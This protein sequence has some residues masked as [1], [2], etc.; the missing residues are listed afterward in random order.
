M[1]SRLE[2]IFLYLF[3]AIACLALFIALLDRLFFLFD[4]ELFWLPFSAGKLFNLSAL[5]LLFVIVFLLRQVRE[6]LKK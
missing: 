2:N 4:Y 1:I 5:C 3:F 6:N